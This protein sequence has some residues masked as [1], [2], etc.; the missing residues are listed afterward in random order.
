VKLTPEQCREIISRI[1]IA[2]DP[3][4]ELCYDAL[5]EYIETEI[6]ITSRLLFECRCHLRGESKKMTHEELMY[7][8]GKIDFSSPKQYVQRLSGHNEHYRRCLEEG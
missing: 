2:E 6:M 5:F 3:A 8:L 1:R 4:N 7:A